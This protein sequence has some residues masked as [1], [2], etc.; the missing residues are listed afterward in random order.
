MNQFVIFR[1]SC[2]EMTKILFG[3]F[4]Y[5]YRS[6]CFSTFR[7]PYNFLNFATTEFCHVTYVNT[8]VDV[9]IR[10]PKSISVNPGDEIVVKCQF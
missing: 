2:T 10:S 9:F 3:R 7:E 8:Y 6:V 1:G 4:L 5:Q